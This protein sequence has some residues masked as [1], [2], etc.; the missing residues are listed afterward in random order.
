MR[1]TVRKKRFVFSLFIFRFFFRLSTTLM[2]RCRVVSM[3]SIAVP[4][5]R[6]CCA[7]SMR[8]CGSTTTVELLTLQHHTAGYFYSP[9]N[10]H[11]D[12]LL[13]T[14]YITRCYRRDGDVETRGW[15]WMSCSSSFS[16]E[17]KTAHA[18]EPREPISLLG[19]CSLVAR[20]RADR[21]S[22]GGTTTHCCC[23]SK[24]WQTT[25]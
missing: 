23:T 8:C 18:P 4:A 11:R 21:Y 6:C 7:S 14:R 20:T 12:E 25:C 10:S 5:T 9:G 19:D 22:Y 17:L 1:G 24:K 2:S 15:L 16:C 13:C 3:L